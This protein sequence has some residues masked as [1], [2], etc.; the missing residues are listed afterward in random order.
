MAAYVPTAAQKLAAQLDGLAP[1]N[2]ICAA[3]N[4][5]TSL[6][7]ISGE[8]GF[9]SVYNSA[10]APCYVKFYDKATAPAVGTDI[11]VHV[12]GGPGNTSGAGAVES[13]VKPLVF[14]TG[15]AFAVV[16]GVANTDNTGVAA[17][18]VVLN[19]GYR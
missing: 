18:N 2:L 14:T 13:L 16:T 10:G 7:A 8:V 12:I 6:K 5:A 3:S 19:I 11:P 17:N 9:I 15:I 1:Y 4:N